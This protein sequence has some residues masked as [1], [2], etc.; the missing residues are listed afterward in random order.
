MQDHD[1]LTDE[2]T[3][4]QTDGIFTYAL[5]VEKSALNSD[6]NNYFILLLTDIECFLFDARNTS[7]H[8]LTV[9][10]VCQRR[11]YLFTL[12]DSALST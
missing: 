10:L 11:A 9:C 1:G 12:F 8:N 3:D 6:K 5:D 7:V 2:Q 4:G